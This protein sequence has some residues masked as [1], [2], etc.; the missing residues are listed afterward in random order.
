MIRRCSPHLRSGCVLSARYLDFIVSWPGVAR[1]GDLVAGGGGGSLARGVCNASGSGGLD[2]LAE[3]GWRGDSAD[4]LR[5]DCGEALRADEAGGLP[6]TPE[7]RGVLIPNP[8]PVPKPFA[9]GSNVDGADG[10]GGSGAADARRGDVDSSSA[11]RTAFFVE[12]AGRDPKGESS[13]RSSLNMFSREGGD[14]IDCCSCCLRSSFCCRC[15][16]ICVSCM[17]ICLSCRRS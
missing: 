14:G 10:V 6:L 7:N 13:G 3:V 15:S 8:F 17:A 9:R 5:T 16:S 11:K 4:G 2:D 12:R 1:G